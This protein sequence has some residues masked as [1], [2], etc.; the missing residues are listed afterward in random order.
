MGRLGGTRITLSH[1]VVAL[2][3]LVVV[4]VGVGA[5]GADADGDLTT[6]DAPVAVVAAAERVRTHAAAD[7][8]RSTVDEEPG[9]PARVLLRARRRIAFRFAI[10][11]RRWHRAFLGDVPI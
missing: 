4:S 7:V 6:I 9:D 5:W 11:M 10:L 3:V 8:D 1:G 2:A